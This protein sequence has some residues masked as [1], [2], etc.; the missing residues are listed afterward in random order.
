MTTVD[1]IGTIL[2]AEERRQGLPYIAGDH[3][4]LCADIDRAWQQA[5]CEHANQ[6]DVTQLDAQK[7][8]SLCNDCGA[9]WEE[10]R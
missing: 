6:L 2:A 10:D 9:T 3:C 5:T 1:D 8:Q 4:A 7:R